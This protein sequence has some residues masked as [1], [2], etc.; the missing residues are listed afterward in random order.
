MA[1]FT[2]F[3]D[4]TYTYLNAE[5]TLKLKGRAW[6]WVLSAAVLATLIAI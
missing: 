5:F 2:S 4:K 6:Q 1:L 3:L